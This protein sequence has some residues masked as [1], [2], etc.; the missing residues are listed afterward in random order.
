MIS[1]AESM[2]RFRPTQSNKKE[3]EK[4]TDEGVDNHRASLLHDLLSRLRD[5]HRIIV[6]LGWGYFDCLDTGDIIKAAIDA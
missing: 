1:I 3:R 6:Y 4:N 2:E 5:C